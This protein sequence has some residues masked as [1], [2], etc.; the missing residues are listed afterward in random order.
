MKKEPELIGQWLQWSEDKRNFPTWYFTRGDDGN[1][2]VGHL[3][4][5][6][7]FDEINTSDAFKACAAFIKLEAERIRILFNGKWH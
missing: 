6:K 1:C 4:E 2:L 7:E 3:P 5:G